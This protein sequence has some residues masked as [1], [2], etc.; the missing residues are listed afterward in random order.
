LSTSVPGKVG[1]AWAWIA[2]NELTTKIADPA[3]KRRAREVFSIEPCLITA[4][5]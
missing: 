2:A 4:S 3:K 5:V 1:S